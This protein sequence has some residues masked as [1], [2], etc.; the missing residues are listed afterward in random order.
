[1]ASLGYRLN[2]AWRV[3]AT[4]W[5]FLSFSIGG[6]L[7]TLT[8]FPLIRLLWRDGDARRDRTQLLIHYVFRFFIAQ[9]CFLG[10]MSVQLQGAKRLKTLSG[11]LLF[12]NHPTLIDVVLLI[13]LMPRA[14]CVVKESL[15]RHRGF[16]GVIRAAGY[17]PN[18]DSEQLLSACRQQLGKGR[19]LI[20]FPEGTRT[21]PGQP[22]RF[23]RGAAHLLLA[24][25]AAVQ[26]VLLTCVPPSLTKGKRWYEIP[27][28]RFHV[29]LTALA[30]VAFEQWGISTESLPLASRQLTR[31]LQQF[32][33]QRLEHH[34]KLGTG[35]QAADY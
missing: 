31:E 26:P 6:V 35:H 20:I 13:S 29:T 3:L 16:G 12:C 10:V 19:P 24:T 23:Q 8:A 30:P 14:D 27:P 21:E 5:C 4:G 34:A 9:M 15:W 1:M 18:R 33:T 28:Q 2:Y 25:E 32:F 7:L 17:I 22:L 11:Q